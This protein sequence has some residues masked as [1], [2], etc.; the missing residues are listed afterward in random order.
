[1]TGLCVALALTIPGNQGYAVFLQARLGQAVQRMNVS[2]SEQERSLLRGLYETQGKKLV[3]LVVQQHSR[4][5]NFGLFC[6]FESTVLGQRMV[7]LGV[8][9]KFIAVVGV[10]EAALK[11]GQ[12][13]P[14]LKR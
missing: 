1:V 10:D 6:L 14:T 13:I 2:L 4:R 7:V 9:T 11:L 8:A 3:E 5:R 12:L